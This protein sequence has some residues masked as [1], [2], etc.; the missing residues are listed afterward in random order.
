MEDQTLGDINDELVQAGQFLREFTGENLN[1][2]QKFC[3]AQDIVQWIKN[4]TE[5]LVY[6]C[7]IK[8]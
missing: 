8:Y 5:G 1:C 3:D 6:I 7:Y 4:T 2:I